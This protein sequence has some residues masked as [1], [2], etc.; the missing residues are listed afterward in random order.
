MTE[1]HPDRQPQ[2]PSSRKA[3]L[4]TLVQEVEE[5]LSHLLQPGSATDVEPPPFYRVS[6][7]PVDPLSRLLWYWRKDLAAKVFLVTIAALLIFS[8]IFAI[9]ASHMLSQLLPRPA[10]TLNMQPGNESKVNGTVDLHPTFPVRH[11][12]AGT[13][14]SSL[15]PSSGTVATTSG[16]PGAQTL[17]IVDIPNQVNAGDTVQVTV[18]GPPNTSVKLTIQYNAQPYY[19]ETSSQ[20]FDDGGKATLDWDVNVSTKGNNNVTAQVTATGSAGQSDT[21]AVQVN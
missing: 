3:A 4:T 13:N 11:G 16:T 6:P 10:P 8:M 15:P 20:T 12:P 14:T 5:K 18:T 7:G 19:A 21:V 1:G 9:A 17:Q 2:E